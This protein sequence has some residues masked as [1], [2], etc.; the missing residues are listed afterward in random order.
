[1]QATIVSNLR[2]YHFLFLS[3][4]G[5]TMKREERFYLGGPFLCRFLRGS[6]VRPI[7]S[8]HT[9]AITDYTP[10]LY[11]FFYLLL[12]ALTATNLFSILPK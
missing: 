12:I 2:G 9:K 4:H 10:H 7:R 8:L 6:Q 3:C 1:M 5:A 11:K